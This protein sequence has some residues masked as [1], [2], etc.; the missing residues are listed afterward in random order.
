MASDIGCHDKDNV[1][2]F[3][4]FALALH[5]GTIEAA[6]KYFAALAE[7]GEVQVPIAETFFAKRY[8]VVADCFGVWWKIIAAD[9]EVV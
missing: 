2:S 8:G 6:E 7:N 9:K 1:A 3:S 5:V 4:G